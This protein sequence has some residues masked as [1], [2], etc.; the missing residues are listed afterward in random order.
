[1]PGVIAIT[2]QSYLQLRY[3]LFRN[4]KNLQNEEPIQ[5]STIKHELVMWKHTDRTICAISKFDDISRSVIK[6]RITFLNEALQR[7]IGGSNHQQK[8]G[9]NL[10]QEKDSNDKQED[11][12]LHLEEMVNQCGNIH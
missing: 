4:I 9:S 3:C 2:I 6:S 5:I 11:L 7:E 1:M 10:E 8:D 12:V